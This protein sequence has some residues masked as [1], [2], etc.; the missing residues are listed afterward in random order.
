[1]ISLSRLIKSQWATQNSEDK[2]VISIRVLET[3]TRN[4][5]EDDVEVEVNPKEM[6]EQA[7]SEAD[8][9]LQDARLQ[10]D[11]LRND[12]EQ[13]RLY[14][15]QQKIEIAEA[16]K[17]EGFTQGL[18]EGRQQGYTE[19]L[20]LINFSKTVVDSSKQ[21]YLN[22]IESA[23]KTILHLGVKVAEKI[24]GLKLEEDEETFL[25]VVKRALKEAREY[26]EIR[27]H[28]DPKY[29]DLLLSQKEEL[30][31]I[32]PLET[33][34]Y[35]YPDDEIQENGCMIESANGRIDASIDSQ[36]QELKQKL[37]ELLESE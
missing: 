13:E 7:R 2:K 24:I 5:D 30:L 32:F 33:D 35:I 11:H 16:A 27:L 28:V 23:E 18:E 6:L 31:A 34:L 1:M 4:L 29:Y 3:L 25:A 22:K 20:D 14:W 37:L 9:I 17:S 19:C 12:L 21:D 10:A 8:S 26:R 15:E 36:L